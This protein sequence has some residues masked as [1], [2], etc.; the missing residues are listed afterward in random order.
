[1]ALAANSAAAQTGPT[2]PPPG[3]ISFNAS[4]LGS[5][6]LGGETWTYGLDNTQYNQLWWTEEF[7]NNVCTPTGCTK[8]SMNF[9]SYNQAAGV[10][11][12]TNSAP[13]TFTS[14]SGGTESVT[15][16]FVLQLTPSTA[17]EVNPAGFP[18]SPAF[19]VPITGSSFTVNFE[20][21]I[22]GE[23]ISDYFNSNN[24][25][26]QGFQTSNQSGF[27]Y[28][29]PLAATPE[30]TSILRFGTGLFLIGGILRRRLFAV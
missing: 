25:G 26:S 12:W 23:S 28:T 1:M 10:A 15:P 3:L 13:W 27:Y 6:Q 21:E 5:T 8:G 17:A 24:G 2:Y 29:A 18:G 7:V 4:G 11:V 16:Q 22:G 30:P 14:G 20:Y 19:V 9:T